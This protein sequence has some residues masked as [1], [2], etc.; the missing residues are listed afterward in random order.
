MTKTMTKRDL[1][2]KGFI[3]FAG[4]NPWLRKAKAETQGRI[5]SQELKAQ[6]MEKA[7]YR[8]DQSALL[9]N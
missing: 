6:A 4:C 1:G 9:Y 8:L 7:A 2:R 3:W 5:W